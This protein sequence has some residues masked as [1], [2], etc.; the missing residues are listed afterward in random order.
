M[1]ILKM[2]DMDMCTYVGQIGTLKEEYLALMP[3]AT[4]KTQTDKLFLVLALLG[5]PSL[6]MFCDQLLASATIPILEDAFALLLC[7]QCPPIVSPPMV[8]SSI[9]A[10]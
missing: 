5:L 2:Q 3:A 1:V 6:S 9:L 8:D 4:H 7:V 10:S